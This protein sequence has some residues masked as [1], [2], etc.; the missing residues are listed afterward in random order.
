MLRLQCKIC[1]RL[2]NEQLLNVDEVV[3]GRLEVRVITPTQPI[4]HTALGPD[5]GEL[6][7]SPASN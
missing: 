1:E 4:I 3:E 6:G 7:K 2:L 5:T